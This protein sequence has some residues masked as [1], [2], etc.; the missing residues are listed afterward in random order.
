MALAAKVLAEINSS[1]PNNLEYG[2]IIIIR[3]Q[4]LQSLWLEKF[5]FVGVAANR[6]Y[7]TVMSLSDVS[8][9][10]VFWAQKCITSCRCQIGF[11]HLWMGTLNYVDK[12]QKMN[13]H[14]HSNIIYMQ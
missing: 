4:K 6:V 9:S 12:F 7:V 5:I 2:Y 8:L 1:G 11:K 13:E 14:L 10:A 3:G